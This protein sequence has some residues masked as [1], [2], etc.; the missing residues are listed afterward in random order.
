MRNPRLYLYVLRDTFVPG[1]SG[2]STVGL[3]SDRIFSGR[4]L[5]FFLYIDNHTWHFVH[6]KA[7]NGMECHFS[8]KTHSLFF[9]CLFHNFYI[10]KNVDLNTFSFII[11]SLIYSSRY[12]F[13]IVWK[14]IYVYTAMSVSSEQCFSAFSTQLIFFVYVC[15]VF[16]KKHFTR[17]Q[18]SERYL[19]FYV[20]VFQSV[21]TRH[22]PV[23]ASLNNRSFLSIH[24]YRCNYK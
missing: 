18:S 21:T 2:V 8:I 12:I 16:M 7:M 9:Y 5:C 6:Y 24:L 4:K 19:R 3:I 10:F 23:T 17:S 13:N 22:D 20:S 11:I 15:R 1:K 14:C